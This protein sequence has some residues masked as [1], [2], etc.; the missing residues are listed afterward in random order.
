MN[1]EFC[2]NAF[3]ACHV[4]SALVC[5]HYLVDIIQSDAETINA[6]SLHFAAAFEIVKNVFQLVFSNAEAIVFESELE[7]VVDYSRKDLN[8]DLLFRIL[9]RII[10]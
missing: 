10:D 4:N 8:L 3:L 5:V 6:F 1:A 2:A 9:H 7:F